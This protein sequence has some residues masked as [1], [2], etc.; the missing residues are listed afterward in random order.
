MNDRALRVAF[1]IGGV[2]SKYPEVCRRWV[3]AMSLGQVDLYVLTDMHDSE[4]ILRQLGDNRL[5]PPFSAA[6]VYPADYAIYGEACKAILCRELDIDILIDDFPGYLVWPWPEI[7]AP[8]R[9]QVVPDPFRPYWS[10]GWKVAECDGDF[11]RRAYVLPS[12]S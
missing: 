6:N 8:M 1:D 7:P 4:K 12:K 2:L 3:L 9:L 5:M 11:G 10:P